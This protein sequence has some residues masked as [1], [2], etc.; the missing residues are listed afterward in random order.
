MSRLPENSNAP[1]IVRVVT[2][3]AVCYLLSFLFH[4]SCTR[5]QY[6]STPFFALY[7]LLLAFP[8]PCLPNELLLPS[9]Q[10]PR[11]HY[12]LPA[13]RPCSITHDRSITSRNASKEH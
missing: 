5:W 8:Q 3:L 2:L 9:S 1:W 10:V 11:F 12:Q 13:V 4:A 7:D 6:K